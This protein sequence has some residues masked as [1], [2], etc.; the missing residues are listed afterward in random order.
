MSRQLRI[1]YEG[2]L[3][4]VMNRGLERKSI[5][6]NNIHK[7]LFLNLLS[8][9][10]ERFKLDIYSYCLMDNHYHLL[11]QTKLPNLNLAMK[12][13]SGVYTL[14]FNSNTK[15]DG[16]LF[17]GRYKSILI[18][19]E[20]YLLNVSR[21]IHKNPSVAKIIDDDQEYPW[22]SYQYYN[23]KKNKKPKWIITSEILK[24]FNYN[25]DE[26]I[27][28]VESGIDEGTKKFYST[29]KTKA[30]F[31]N[32]LF[33]KEI[34]DKFL[35]DVIKKE[36]SNGSQVDAVK[37]PSLEEI[38]DEITKK[39]K[40][41]SSLVVNNHSRNCIFERNL[42]IYLFALNPRYSMVE[43]GKFLGISGDAI[44]KSSKKFV[45]KLKID[46]VLNAE[47]ELIRSKFYG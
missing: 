39:Y 23:L 27:S 8:E 46:K 45:D 19:K 24:Y 36:I 17:R 4:H 30:I 6:L 21:Y 28:F 7:E 32:T 13:L 5:F 15:R 11:V 38:V 43:K 12:Y 2:A 14:R 47:V 42:T 34:T 10:S 26:Y 18:D 3:Y 33:V 31:G 44:S 20:S 40:I 37:Y 35:G 25:S 41:D 9:V 1:E 22:S 16:P 29:K